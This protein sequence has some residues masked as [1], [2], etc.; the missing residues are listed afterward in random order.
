MDV[1]AESTGY[2]SVKPIGVAYLPQ[3]RAIVETAGTVMVTSQNILFK[4]KRGSKRRTRYL[5]IPIQET[6]MPTK[7]IPPKAPKNRN[8]IPKLFKGFLVD[9]KV[10]YIK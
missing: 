9:L 2:Q 1:Y 8:L 4:K 5:F 6:I 3:N 10:R 7:K